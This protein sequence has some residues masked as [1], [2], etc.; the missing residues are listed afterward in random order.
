MEAAQIAFPF[1]D[2][3]LKKQNNSTKHLGQGEAFQVRGLITSTCSK[4]QGCA[5]G[6]LP[7]PKSFPCP[8]GGGQKLLL[9]L[10][11]RRKELC[12]TGLFKDVSVRRMQ[13]GI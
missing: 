11:M 5:S 3:L 13:C 9:I 2:T 8:S 10:E 6:V 1:L 7:T 12:S 4:A